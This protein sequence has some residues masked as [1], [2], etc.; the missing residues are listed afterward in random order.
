[1]EFGPDVAAGAEAKQ[2]HGL[3]AVSQRHDEQPG[4]AILAAEWIAHH[5]TGAVIHLRLF[6]GSGLDHHAGGRGL[7][8]AQ[9]LDE[10]L[11]AG[12]A[13]GEA[14]EG[15]QVL[16]DRHGIAAAGQGQLDQFPVRLAGAG[17][18]TP[19]RAYRTR[20]GGFGQR[21]ACRHRKVGS[22][23]H[24]RFCHLRVG[25]HLHGR[26]CRRFPS[27][28][29]RPHRYPG[30]PQITARGFSADADLPLDPPQRPSQSSQR[31]DLLLLFLAQDIG[32]ADGRLIA[33]R[34]SQRPGVLYGRF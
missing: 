12:I 10:A 16:P 26:F 15:N 28:P 19:P 22:H 33:S 34:Q 30:G 27:P 21:L 9:L 32:H 24:G 6:A 20:G 18:W 5:G 4:A 1:M 8:A 31:Y 2:T 25:G 3:A 23:L 29:G 11:D 17:A 7:G 13:A 14:M